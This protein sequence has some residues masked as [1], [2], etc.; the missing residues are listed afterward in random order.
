MYPKNHPKNQKMCQASV[1]RCLEEFFRVADPRCSNC[2]EWHGDHEA[3]GIHDATEWEARMSAETRW[4][5]T[6][7]RAVLGAL[8]LLDTEWSS[9]CDAIRDMLRM[10]V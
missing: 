2:A 6:N 10:A 4:I 3:Y 1:A 5:F 7:A 9:C 8:P